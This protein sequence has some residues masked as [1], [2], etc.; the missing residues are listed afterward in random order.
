MKEISPYQSGSLAPMQRNP[1]IIPSFNNGTWVAS[2]KG[3]IVYVTR[4]DTVSVHMMNSANAIRISN[5]GVKVYLSFSDNQYLATGW[6]DN[7][8]IT[9]DHSFTCIASTDFIQTPQIPILPAKNEIIQLTPLSIRVPPNLL[10][11]GSTLKTEAYIHMPTYPTN[12]T[13]GMSV[14]LGTT[15][16]PNTFFNYVIDANGSS[17]WSSYYMYSMITFLADSAPF[18]CNGYGGPGSTGTSVMSISKGAGNFRLSD[19]FNITPA[20]NIGGIDVDLRND[21]QMWSMIR[22][23]YIR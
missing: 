22:M 23:E 10:R 11:T 1:V 18:A 5:Y 7:I 9:N 4:T 20:V 3:S 16:Q 14:L 13:R 21:Y 12:S 19:G 15:D 2:Q 8:V 17:N 6:Y